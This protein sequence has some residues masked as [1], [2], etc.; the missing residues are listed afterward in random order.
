MTPQAHQPGIRRAPLTPAERRAMTSAVLARTTG[1]VCQR[2]LALVGGRPDEPLDTQTTALVAGH[3]GHCEQCR[4]IE[5]TLAETRDVLATLAEIEPRSEFAAQVVAATS[6]R[7]VPAR[8]PTWAG[9]SQRW[10]WAG[11]LRDRA[12]FTWDRVLARPRLSLE[13]AYLATVLL[14]IIIGNP[15]LIADALGAR[16]SRFVSGESA[17]RTAG[18]RQ[19]GAARQDIESVMPA[20]VGRAMREV[21]S[22]QASAAKGWNWFVERTS[23][24]WSASWDWLRELFGW[25][26]AQTAPPA[27]TEPAKA[28]LRGSQ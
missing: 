22:K 26:G 23:Q 5:Q 27:P 3:L 15:G 7:R 21:E 10:A 20:F 19:Q 11:A 8:R 6:G 4:A 16:S 14:V 2:A 18:V 28:P 17:S 13:L 1:S 25:V 24:L 9:L 12:A